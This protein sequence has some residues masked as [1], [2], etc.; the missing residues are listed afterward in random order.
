MWL[1]KYIPPNGFRI[2]PQGIRDSP[3]VDSLFPLKGFGIPQS[4]FRISLGEF[5]IS[6]S[7]IPDSRQVNSGLTQ[8]IPYYPLVYSRFLLSGIWF[9]NFSKNLHSTL[10]QI[11]DWWIWITSYAAS[12]LNR[13]HSFWFTTLVSWKPSSTE[14]KQTKAICWLAKQRLTAI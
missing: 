2:P 6:S 7:W 3:K 14:S 10:K 9:L 5:Q 13:I 12:F 11:L 8:W 1:E 4:R